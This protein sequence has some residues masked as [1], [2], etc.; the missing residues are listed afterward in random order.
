MMA[1]DDDVRRH[2]LEVANG[3]DERLA[4]GDGASRQADID[5][6][7]RKTFDSE[8]M[9]V[10]ESKGGFGGGVHGA[11]LYRRQSHGDKRPVR[12]PPKSKAGLPSESMARKLCAYILLEEKINNMVKKLSRNIDITMLCKFI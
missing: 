9:T 4:L 8:E 6:V 7:R 11:G 5:G 12:P 2:R 1:Y 10:R 3:I